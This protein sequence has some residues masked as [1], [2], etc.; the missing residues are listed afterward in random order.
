M[1]GRMSDVKGNTSKRTLNNIFGMKSN[2]IT[3][4][5]TSEE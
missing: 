1:S 2:R 3:K 5:E 4:E